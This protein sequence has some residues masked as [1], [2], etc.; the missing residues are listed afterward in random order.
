MRGL[1]LTAS[2]VA[3]GFL[4]YS[5]LAPFLRS[6]LSGVRPSDPLTVIAATLSLAATASLA[7]WLRRGEL[8]M[9]TQP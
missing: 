4:L 8:H 3:A 9:S 5:T 7:S 6:F 2:G 1:V